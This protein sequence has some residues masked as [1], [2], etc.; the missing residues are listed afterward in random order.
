MEWS[1]SAFTVFRQMSR[2]CG[3]LSPVLS[4]GGRAILRSMETMP[5]DARMNAPAHLHQNAG[6]KQDS[7]AAESMEAVSAA[8]PI[9]LRISAARRDIRIPDVP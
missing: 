1:A 7:N 8:A 5:R 9:P 3:V 6:M 2:K 4:S